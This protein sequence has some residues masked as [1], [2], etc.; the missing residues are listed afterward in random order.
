DGRTG[1]ALIE[2]VD[3][4]IFTGS[5]ATGR[6][7]GEAAAKRFIPAFLELGGKD[8]ALVLDD[9]DIERTAAS[10]AW[11]GLANAGQ[12]CLSI[13]RGYVDERIR[14]RFVA[15]LQRCVDQL[16][17]NVDAIDA[18]QIGPVIA[19]RQAEILQRHLDDALSQGARVINGGKLVHSGGIWCQ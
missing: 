3:M 17:N 16:R 6:K 1:A 9:A 10:I 15:A 14:D 11:G 12:S 13:E 19:L 4:I 2:Q 5:V 18:G 8:P 7:V